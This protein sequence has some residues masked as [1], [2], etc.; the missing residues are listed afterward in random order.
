MSDRGAP[1]GAA[2]ILLGALVGGMIAGRFE[3]VFGCLGVAAAGA[4]SLG[5]RPRAGALLGLAGVCTLA[6]LMNFLL[7]RGTSV[8]GFSFG[9]LNGTR[10]GASLGIVMAAR[11]A[12]A[13]AALAGLRAVWPGERAADEVAR[14]LLPLRRLGVPVLEGRSI[15][16]LA[17]RF[18]PLIAEES[19]RIAR[20]QELRAAAPAR[21]WRERG[22]RLRAR[23]VP[24]LASS[25]ERAESVGLALE[26]RYDRVRP[27]PPRA[28]APLAARAAGVLLAAGSLLWRA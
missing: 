10:E 16:S 7:V 28:A 12:A 14:L 22:V 23:L 1:G 8:P 4:L 5:V 2:P 13:A 15:F 18:A 11:L 9:V 27:L 26:A 17:L 25:L 6:F 20:Q 21:G 3:T 24:T 19:R